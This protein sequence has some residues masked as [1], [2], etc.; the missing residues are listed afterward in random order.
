MRRPRWIPVAIGVA[1]L[2]G[3]GSLIVAATRNRASAAPL[4]APCGGATPRLTVEGT[5]QALGQ[6]DSLA[7]DAQVSVT[8]P[9]AQAALAADDSTTTAVVQA[10]VAS[11]VLSKDIET[12]DLTINPNYT[13]SD[14]RTII[15]GYNVDNSL[16]VTVRKIA[17]AGAV[18]DAATTAGGDV[19]SV[20]SLT[21]TRSDPRALEDQAR[22]DAVRQ[23]VTHAGAMAR[24]AGQRLGAVCSLTDQSNLDQT[25]SGQIPLSAGLAQATA[26]VPLEGGTQQASAQVRLVYELTPLARR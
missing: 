18:V 14:G 16:A 24:A 22:R 1:L 2:L 25:P 26:S 13:F 4:V 8:A 6:P 15:S 23:A 11:G 12:T 7:F 19:L 5:G 20:E 3:A 10:I 21:F 9:S 17:S